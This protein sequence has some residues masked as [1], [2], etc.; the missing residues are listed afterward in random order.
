[1]G[2]LNVTPDSFFDGGKFNTT[3]K[4]VEH[5]LKMIADG[6]DII[7][8]GGESTKPGAKPLSVEE[9]KKRIIP[10]LHKLRQ[11]T[12]CPIS[13]DTTKS[14][15]AAAA[16]DFGA[17]LVND[18][19]AGQFDSEMLPLVSRSKV[20]ICL[21]HMQGT[22]ETMQKNP[23]Y[24]NVV[25]EVKVFL[26]QRMTACLEAGIEKEKIVLDPGIGFGKSVEDNLA[27]LKNLDQFQDLGC[28]ILIGT[29]RKSFI[30]ALTGATVEDRLPGSLA[31]L[32][33]AVQKGAQ[34]VRVHDVAETK[35]FL[36]LF[37]QL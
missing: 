36:S 3:E 11:A 23:H 32:A 6:A 31:T 15:V 37:A 5:A 29:S 16:I 18:I 35:Q 14:F 22:P 28:P 4:A 26:R 25:E 24:K 19:S 2:V 12:Q 13:I 17:T 9:E 10:I 8:I 30:G 7:D 34:I 33:A 27:L 20:R 1:M 21:M